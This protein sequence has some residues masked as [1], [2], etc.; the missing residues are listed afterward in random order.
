MVVQK[1]ISKDVAQR[2]IHA[3]LEKEIVK[4]MM[5][6]KEISYVAKITAMISLHG[7]LQIVVQR[8]MVSL[9]LRSNQRY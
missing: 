4:T 7:I 1:K 8:R 6:V 9:T 2:K 3:V 5:I